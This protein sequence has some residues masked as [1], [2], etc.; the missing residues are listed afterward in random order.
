MS[1][2]KSFTSSRMK[3]IDLFMGRK[4]LR[5]KD[6]VLG[7]SRELHIIGNVMMLVLCAALPQVN[8]ISLLLVSP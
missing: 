8:T 7:L 3:E 5:R 4:I 2:C 6:I 1:Q